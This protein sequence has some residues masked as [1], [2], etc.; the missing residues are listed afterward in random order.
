MNTNEDLIYLSKKISKFVVGIE[1]NTSKKNE[2]GLSIKSSGSKLESLSSEDIVDFDLEGNQL[3]NFKR[4][5]SMELGFH[6]YL[7]SQKNI[8]YVAHTHPVNVLKILSSNFCELF[9]NNR[10][11]P[12]QVIFNGKKSCL[13]PYSKPGNDLTNSIKKSVTEF[14]LQEGFFPKL[15]LLKNHGIIACGETVDECIII[16]EICEKSAEIFLG[17]LNVGRINFFKEREIMELI[18]DENEIYRKSLI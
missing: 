2:L 17:S 13:V 8:K 9:S 18:N 3:N 11:F 10:F 6:L 14:E 5:G 4:R 7:L 15:I 12:D 16:S 1:G